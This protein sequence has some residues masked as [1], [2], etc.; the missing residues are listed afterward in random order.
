MM[1]LA[2][3][4]R[5]LPVIVLPTVCKGVVARFL[6]KKLVPRGFMTGLNDLQSYPRISP[7]VLN[8]LILIGK[9]L[10]L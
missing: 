5:D 1:T 8:M 10:L 2:S 7:S 4:V 3:S 9:Y 6:W